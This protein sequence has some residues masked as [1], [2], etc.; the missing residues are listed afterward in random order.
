MVSSKAGMT[1]L[2][3]NKKRRIR[4]DSTDYTYGY[5]T[6]YLGMWLSQRLGEY[7][8]ALRMT[9]GCRGPTTPGSSKMW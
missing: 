1:N 2:V 8:P 6:G 5:T 7:A 4:D 3:M 9:V